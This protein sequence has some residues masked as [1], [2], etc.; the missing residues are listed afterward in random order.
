MNS[1]PFSMQGKVG[2]VAGLANEDSI[3]F[4]CAKALHAAGAEM[5]VTCASSK[6]ERFVKPLLPDMG[7][8]ELMVC[9]VQQ[10]EQLSALFERANQ[11]WG[12]VDFVIHSIAF[13]PL[14][15]LHGRVVDCSRDGFLQA[16]DISCHS[17]MRMSKLAEPLMKDG[18]SLISMTYHG[19]EK[20]VDSYNLMG[21]V[22]AALEAAT[23]YMAAELGPQGI[24]VHAVSPGVIRTRAASG[25][26]EIEALTK[27]TEDRAPLK[28]LATIEDVGNAVVYLTAPSGAALSGMTHYVDAGY[29]IRA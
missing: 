25:L 8:P 22:K 2:I 18:G 10:D 23:R 1:H 21:P 3:A 7:D 26:K 11:R 29:H 17:F 6:A 12:R 19:A 16:M 5:L 24:R 15:D 28:R 13:A 20:V 4:G 9:D 14:D 27:D